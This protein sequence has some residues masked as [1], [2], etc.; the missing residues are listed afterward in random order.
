MGITY[1]KMGEKQ[2]ARAAWERSLE[3]NPDNNDAKGWLVISKSD[4]N[5]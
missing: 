4:T 3:L 1:W 5:F 2:L